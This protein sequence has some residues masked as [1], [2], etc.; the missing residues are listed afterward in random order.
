[1]SPELSRLIKGG[2]GGGGGSQLA[3]RDMIKLVLS[4]AEKLHTRFS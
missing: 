3:A 1:M 2:G 4:I